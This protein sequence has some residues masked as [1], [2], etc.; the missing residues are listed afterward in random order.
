MFMKQFEGLPRG[1]DYCKCGNIKVEQNPLCTDCKVV[2]LR[3]F[4][5]K[6]IYERN[7]R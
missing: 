7:I 5:L 2:Y 4:K 3:K 1:L 6:R